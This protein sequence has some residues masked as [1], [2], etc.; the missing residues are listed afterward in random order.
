MTLEGYSSGYNIY[1]NFS[2]NVQVTS[3]VMLSNNNYYIVY[4]YAVFT[5]CRLRCVKSK[6]EMVHF[7]LSQQFVLDTFQKHNAS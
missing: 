2:F 7:P 4:R 1:Y 3:I 5:C 6:T